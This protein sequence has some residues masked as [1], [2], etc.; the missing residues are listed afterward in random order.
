VKWCYMWSIALY[1]A[2]ICTLRRILGK[3]SGSFEVCCCRRIELNWTNR[4]KNEKVLH[5]ANEETNIAA[6]NKTKE[7]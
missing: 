6:Y 7:G 1:G 3:Y 4:V 2:K 5:S